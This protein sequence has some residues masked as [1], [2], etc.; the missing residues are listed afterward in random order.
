MAHM[1]R[2][3]CNL[4]GIYKGKT[5]ENGGVGAELS[6]GKGKITSNDL[7]GKF[8]DGQISDVVK[9]IKSGGAYVNV[10]TQQHQDGE[11]RGQIT[12]G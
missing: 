10:V 11:I 7:F 4:T 3:S 12:S 1:L 8:E 9:L 6:M 2:N 5:G